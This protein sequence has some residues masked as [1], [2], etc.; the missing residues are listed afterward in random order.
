[1]VECSLECQRRGF[2][3]N[4]LLNKSYL[5]K[6]LF[7]KSFLNLFTGGV[8]LVGLHAPGHGPPDHL[9]AEVQIRNQAVHLRS[10]LVSQ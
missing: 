3:S 2:E 7:L 8:R 10:D 1:M 4:F 6:N 9:E 5:N